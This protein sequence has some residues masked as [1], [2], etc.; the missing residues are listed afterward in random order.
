M[1]ALRY[2]L[3]V[4]A[5]LSVLSVSAQVRTQDWGKLP[6]IQ[7]HSTSVMVGSGSTLPSAAAN[8]AV[9]TGN[10]PGSY[11][12]AYAP[13]GP[14]RGNVNPEGGPDEGDNSEPYEDPIGDAALPLALM[15]CAYH[16]LR[17]TRKRKSAMS[18]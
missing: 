7:M 15:A 1:K 10:V 4:V 12:P 6:Q 8:G 9:I 14:R 5:M 16:I 11:S 2:L 13:S 17:V 3:I 18:K